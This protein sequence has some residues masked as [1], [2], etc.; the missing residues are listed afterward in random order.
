[1]RPAGCTYFGGEAPR[2][3]ARGSV[4]P[5][6]K[7]VVGDCEFE[8]SRRQGAGLKYRKRMRRRSGE[9]GQYRQSPVLAWNVTV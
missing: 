7:G 8:R 3:P 5:N 9:G 4:S 2:H 1:M 6:G